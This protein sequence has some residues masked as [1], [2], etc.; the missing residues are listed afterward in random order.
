MKTTTVSPLSVR[1][2]SSLSFLRLAALSC[3]L[4]AAPLFAEGSVEGRVFNTTNGQFINNARITI[5]GSALETFTDEQG[6]YRL[7]VPAGTR[8]VHVFYTSLKSQVRLVQVIDGQRV[9]SDFNLGVGAATDGPI[10]LDPFVV[11]SSRDMNAAAVAIN[12]QRFATNIKSVMSTDSFG[13]IAEGNVGDFAKFLPGVTIDYGGGGARGISVGGVPTSSTP[14]MIDGN[15]LASAASSSPTR[16]IELEQVSI[17]NMS[18]VEVSR[19]PNADSPASA[20]GGWVNLISRNAFERAKPAYTLKTYLSFREN[21]I[22]HF[23]IK[24]SPGPYRDSSYKLGANLDF[25]AIVPVNKRFGFTISGLSTRTPN[26]LYAARPGWVPNV[27]ASSA[28][29][30]APS[31]DQPYLGSYNL[32]VGTNLTYRNSIGVTVDFRLTNYDTIST[33]FQYSYHQGHSAGNSIVFEPIRVASFGPTFTQGAVAAGRVQ[34]S[35]SDRDKSGTT[36]MPSLR[37]VH[38]G[39]VWRWEVN[40][41]YSN[42]SNHYRDISEGYWNETN[43]FIRNVTIRF[44]HPGLVRPE[45]ITVT[46]AAGR[47]VN[48]YDLSNSLFETGR[49]NPEDSQ[50]TVRTLRMNARRRVDWGIPL[51][52]KTGLDIQSQHRDING[53][54]TSF[55]YVGADGRAA[56]VDNN[57]AQW[58]AEEMSRTPQGF[59]FAPRDIMSTYEIGDTFKAHPEYFQLTEAQEVA[60]YRNAVNGSKEIT[61]TIY[62]PYVRFDTKLLRDRLTIATG[63]R[64]ERTEDDGT[65]ALVDPGRNYQ[66]DA[67]GA[68]LRNAAGQPLLIA[69]AD[70]M[71]AVQLTST[72]RG[73][74]ADKSYD[75]FFPSFNAAFSFTEKLLG[76]VSYARSIARPDFG[77]ILPALSLPDPTSTNRTITLTNP[78][79]K[80]WTADSYGVSLEYYFDEPSSGVL[81]ARGYRRDISDF[82][83]LV[84]TQPTEELL[85]AYGIDPATYNAAAGYLIS[86]RLNGGDA[87]ISGLEFDYRQNLSFLNPWVRGVS[88]FGNITM[89]HLQGSQIADFIGYVQKTINF[90]FSYSRTRF[91]GRVAVNLRGRERL[92]AFIG[93]GAEPGTYQYK[94]PRDYIDVS[95]EY[96]VTRHLALFASA[97]DLLGIYND[98]ERYGPSTPRYARLLLR[99][100]IGTLVNVGL[101]AQF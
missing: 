66:R 97:R 83:G 28:N 17:N 27:V 41:A 33:G 53:A 63:V 34:T 46:D 55:T 18:R 58:L 77:N 1:L 30:P 38:H 4:I 43:A 10:T 96:R 29:L 93:A 74:R 21:D 45:S 49:T 52:I 48:P 40:A 90:G 16:E 86:T 84:Q 8:A 60:F 7:V 98:F 100:D 92:A 89:Q 59:G 26:R 73:A 12:E 76:R 61:E 3:T 65:G 35:T 56:T 72:R 39:P 85:N 80:P 44:D 82:W 14:V 64:F 57:A 31:P 79:L 68:I 87:K 50:D 23:S 47:P 19:S 13:E 94:N 11:E 22:D 69:P 32:S 101:K 36:W 20:I 88:T 24:K 2:A 54:A 70:S 37:Y 78:S 15:L 91:T 71:Q 6:Y 81:S 5:E 51:V 95:A 42:A 99:Q 9:V 25:S 75:G 67:A 62:A